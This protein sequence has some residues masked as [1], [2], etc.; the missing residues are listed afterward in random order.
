MMVPMALRDLG[1]EMEIICYV[2][3]DESPVRWNADRSQYMTADFRW[4]TPADYFKALNAQDMPPVLV[5]NAVRQC[6]C[7][8][9]I[10]PTGRRGRPATKCEACRR[11][12]H[13]LVTTG[14]LG[15]D[16]AMNRR[17]TGCNFTTEGR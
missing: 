9:V 2:E 16:G 5:G 17:C 13:H 3:T 4:H 10:P 15:P 6:Q 14:T 11:H 1:D 12:T 8:N 7:G